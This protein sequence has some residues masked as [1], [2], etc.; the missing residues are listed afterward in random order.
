[1]SIFRCDQ[2]GCI[3]NTA[4]SRY[5]LRPKGTLPL[6]SACDPEIG[7]WHGRFPQQSAVGW[8]LA[9]DG[10]LYSKADVASDHFRWRME[11]QGLTVVREILPQE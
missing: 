8:M 5:W 10:Y 9:S 4:T 7:R 11:H 1:M 2:C 6:C 3:E